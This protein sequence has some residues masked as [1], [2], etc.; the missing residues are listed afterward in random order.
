MPAIAATLVRRQK[1]MR[2]CVEARQ[3]RLLLRSNLRFL[4]TMPTE[5]DTCRKLVVTKLQVAG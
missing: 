2:I 5:A 4:Q 1:R 3:H